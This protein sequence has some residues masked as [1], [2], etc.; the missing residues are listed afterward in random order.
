MQCELRRTLY[1]QRLGW[2]TYFIEVT[3]RVQNTQTNR[4]NDTTQELITAFTTHRKCSRTI[5]PTSSRRRSTL[6]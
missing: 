5:W 6:G 1:D 3:T 2:Q 4:Q